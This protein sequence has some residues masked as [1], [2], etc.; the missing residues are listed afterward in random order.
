MKKAELKAIAEKYGM[1]FREHYV[2]CERGPGARRVYQ[3][4]CPT[5]WL[6]LWW[7]A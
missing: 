3:V 7:W 2:T 4:V 6:N 1:Q 5:N